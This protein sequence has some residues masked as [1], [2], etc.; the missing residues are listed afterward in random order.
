MKA[1]QKITHRSRLSDF[2]TTEFFCN[3]VA[4]LGSQLGPTLFQLPP[5][6]RKDADKLREFVKH[7]PPTAR[8]AFEFRHKS[9]FDDETFEILRGAGMALCI[10]EDE[11]LATPLIPTANYGYLRLRK[12]NYSPADLDDWAAKL[13]AQPWADAFVYFKHEDAAQGTGFAADFMTRTS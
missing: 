7:V 10:A 1:S 9:W 11:E 3:R 13:R 6:V 2:E 8:A 12:Q 5:S 4:S